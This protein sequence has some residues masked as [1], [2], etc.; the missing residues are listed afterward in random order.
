M[1]TEEQSEELIN[2]SSTNKILK[3]AYVIPRF[4]PFKGGAE[5]NIYS[6]A[7]RMAENGHEVTVIT[8][9]VKFRNENLPKEEI[10]NGIKIVRLNAWNNALYL[11]FYPGLL[12]YLLRNRFDVVHSSGFGFMW[13]EFCLVLKRIFSRKTKMINTPHGPFMAGDENLSG[14][15]KYIKTSYTWILKIINPFLYDLVIAVNPKQHEW[16]T[17][18]YKIKKEKIVIIPNGIDQKYIEEDIVEHKKDDKLVITYLNRHEWYKGI[19]TVVQAMY[20]ILES[21]PNYLPKDGIQ[22]FIMGRSGNYTPKLTEMVQRLGL[23]EYIKFIFSPTDEERDRIFADES[24]INILPSNWEATGIALI[25][26]MAKGNVIITT[27]QNECWDLLIREGEN[28]FVFNFNDV[29]KLAEILE[30][31][32]KDHNLRESMRRKNLEEAHNYTWEAIFPEYLAVVES[33]IL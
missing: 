3:I 33:L 14:S 4:H 27:Y 19:Q 25:E 8:T 26:A 15:K 22:F 9:N 20:K 16:M 21:K 10:Y 12:P 13:R 23:Q 1:N 32:I 24:Q 7:I 6:M 5:N 18:E 11:G 30:T 29:D 28:G 31:L 17:N 2:S